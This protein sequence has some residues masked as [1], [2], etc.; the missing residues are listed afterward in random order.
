[1]PSTTTNP[2]IRSYSGTD[3]IYDG[4]YY[5]L[6]RIHS[7]RELEETKNYAHVLNKIKWN[8][9]MLWEREQKMYDLCYAQHKRPLSHNLMKEYEAVMASDFVTVIYAFM[10]EH[11]LQ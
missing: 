8:K 4:T 2:F 11:K 1:M 10:T 7:T 9:K 6:S 5:N 3:E